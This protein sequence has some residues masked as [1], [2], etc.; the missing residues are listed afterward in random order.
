MESGAVATNWSSKEKREKKHMNG[1]VGGVWFL[2]R[3]P[4]A[5]GAWSKAGPHG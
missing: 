3:F 1:V 5:I 4:G 2:K